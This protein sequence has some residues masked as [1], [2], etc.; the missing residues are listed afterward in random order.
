MRPSRITFAYLLIIIGMPVF[1]DTI[2]VSEDHVPT[3]SEALSM[4][5]PGDVIIVQPGLYREGNII[6]NKKITLT[7]IKYPVAD[8]SDSNEVFT[9]MSDSVVISGFQVQNCGVS[10]V[11]DRAGIRID[12]QKGCV[13]ENNRLINTFFGIYLKNASDCLILNNYIEGVAQD[14]FSSG[15][16]IHLWYSKNITVEGNTCLQH[17]DG[18][19]LEFVENSMIRKNHSE[20]NLR[21]GLHFMFSNNDSYVEN[22]F[23]D[24][25]AGV[26]VMFSHHITMQNN[27]FLKNWGSS[28]YGL[29]L[30]DISDGEMTGNVFRENTV[31]IYGDGAN[32]IRM[33][34]NEFISNGYALKILGSCSG[35]TI[36]GNNFISNT[37][38]VFTNT[39]GNTNT[40]ESN[41][42]SD[43]TGYDL[44]RDNKGD[45][46][47]RPVKL[48]SYITGRIPASMILLRSPFVDLVNFAEKVMPSITPPTLEDASPLMK[49]I[50]LN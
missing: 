18:I 29:L 28:A 25:G 7:G 14:E 34:G 47:Y 10:Y 9:I 17:R 12:Q 1:S 21:Y 13:I 11:K 30:K 2:Y 42:W 41:F 35:N 32:R 19:Y 8:G 16:A 23:R 20:R 31:G 24:N 45:V 46:P 40:F 5:E 38:D 50:I 39:S 43:Y 37:F 48:F 27:H 33:E 44:D 36:T 15:N 49:M 4:S 26:A 3:I 6:I 22:T